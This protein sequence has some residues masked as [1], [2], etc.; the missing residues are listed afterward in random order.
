ML[1]L[2]GPTNNLAMQKWRRY[3]GLPTIMTVRS[4]IYSYREV[5]DRW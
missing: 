1:N 3:T 4:S 5:P 2:H